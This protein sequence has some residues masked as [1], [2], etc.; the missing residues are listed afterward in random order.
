MSI[1][2]IL[3]H[4]TSSDVESNRPEASAQLAAALGARLVCLFVERSGRHQGF[5]GRSASVVFDEEIHNQENKS[6]DTIRQRVEAVTKAAHVPLSCVLETEE[7][8]S[9]L[10]EY[11]HTVDLTIVA[12]PHFDRLEDRLRYR[13][14]EEIIQHAGGLVLVIPEN[15]QSP[16]LE[17]VKHALVCWNYSAEAIRAVRSSLP[18]LQRAGKVSL[19]LFEENKH[20][21]A[22][23]IFDFFKAHE[24]NVEHVKPQK[25]NNLAHSLL[26]TAKEVD[27]SLIITG[28]YG[29][30]ALLERFFKGATRTILEETK[31]PTL[32]CH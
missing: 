24:I 13:L 2:N 19:C 25:G 8:L 32:M 30:G 23:H 11:I 20:I 17:N 28:A 6:W 1:K 14:P 22:Q 5:H 4:M 12:Q 16:H 26:A 31:I 10:L 3:L 7:H 21:P 18:I 9:A 15:S 27:A 29:S